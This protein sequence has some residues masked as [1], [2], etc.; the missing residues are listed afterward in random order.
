MYP[1]FVFPF[2]MGPA[3]RSF[4]T[5]LLYGGGLL[6]TLPAYPS[7]KPERVLMG[8]LYARAEARGHPLLP[9]L[10][11]VV[12]HVRLAQKQAVAEIRALQALGRRIKCIVAVYP[13]TREQYEFWTPLHPNCLALAAASLRNVQALNAASVEFM[14]RAYECSLEVHGDVDAV[15]SEFTT[16]AERLGSVDLL[17]AECA[18]NRHTS[19]LR[20]KRTWRRRF[21]RRSRSCRG[22]LP[23]SPNALGTG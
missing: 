14:W 1:S 13:G 12:H 19:S 22:W 17:L 4:T 18:L 21:L 2:H 15:L 3:V 6:T 7:G 20:S 16:R 10:R 11:G 23:T 9:F 5:P 8:T